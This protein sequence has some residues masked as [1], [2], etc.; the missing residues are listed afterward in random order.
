[1]IYATWVSG[2]S[3]NMEIKEFN[4]MVLAADSLRYEMLYMVMVLMLSWWMV[5]GFLLVPLLDSKDPFSK[6][7]NLA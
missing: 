6:A 3:S 1:M 5:G 4:N 2:V 7:C